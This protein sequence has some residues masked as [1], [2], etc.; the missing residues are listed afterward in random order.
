[1]SKN[2]CDLVKQNGS[3]T[4]TSRRIVR[5][6]YIRKI[7]KE[8]GVRGG[9]PSLKT[10]K[11]TDILVNQNDEQKPTPSSSSSSSSSTKIKDKK[12]RIFVIPSLEDVRAYCQERENG[13]DPELFIDKYTANGWMVGKNKMKDW[14]AAVR[15]WEKND[16]SKKQGEYL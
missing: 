2:I 4:I 14:K 13:I 10:G 1:M 15:T 12:I 11:N 3:I 7:R 9:N 5:D 16:F 6:E 8:A